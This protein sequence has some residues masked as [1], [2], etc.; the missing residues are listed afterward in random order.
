MQETRLILL[1]H[2]IFAAMLCIACL[3]TQAGL[4]T[5]EDIVGLGGVAVLVGIDADDV[6]KLARAGSGRLIVEGLSTDAT[7]AAEARV[8]LAK[9]GLFPLAD[10][11][12]MPTL[13]KLP[14]VDAFASL[15]VVDRDALGKASPDDAEIKRVLGWGRSAWVHENGKWRR[16]DKPITP[17][18]GEWTHILHGP[19]RVPASNDQVLGPW[20]DSVRWIAAFAPADD[21]RAVGGAMTMLSQRLAGGRCFTVVSH[22]KKDTLEC[23]DAY[24]GTRV[25]MRPIAWG[26][27]G[28]SAR[29]F[30]SGGTLVA[31]EKEVFCYIDCNRGLVALDA[32]T[33]EFLREYDRTFKLREK[34]SAWGKRGEAP[35]QDPGA[36]AASHVML[37]GEALLQSYKGDVWRLNRKTGEIIWHYE[38]GEELWIITPT[39]HDGVIYSVLMEPNNRGVPSRLRG[40]VAIDA[41]TGK[42]L[43]RKQG[44]KGIWSTGIAGVHDT[45]IPVQVLVLEKDAIRVD[46]LRDGKDEL[47]GFD[48]KTGEQIW[49]VEGGAYRGYIYPLDDQLIE[50]PAY[51][52]IIMR[53]LKTG[54]VKDKMKYS[55]DGG[56][57][58]FEVFSGKFQIRGSQLHPRDNPKAGYLNNGVRPNCERPSIPAYGAI[59]NLTSS[60]GCD[61]FLPSG[62]TCA[63]TGRPLQPWPND[64]RHRTDG[65]ATLPGAVPALTVSGPVVDDWTNTV[66]HKGKGKAFGWRNMDERGRDELTR[67]FGNLGDGKSNIRWYGRSET[68]PVQLDAMHLVAETHGWRLEAREGEAPEPMDW[69]KRRALKKKGKL[70]P[71]PKVVWTYLA[72]GRIGT[73]PIIVDD[74]AIFGCH[75]GWVY[76]VRVKDGSLAWRS[77]AA[78]QEQ[79]MGAFSQVESSWPC[80]GVVEHDGQILTVAGRISTMDR[81]LFACA[82]DPDTG[83]QVW[84][85]RLATD[86]IF[87]DDSSKQLGSDVWDGNWVRHAQ[88]LNMPPQ[89]IDDRLRVLGSLL[90]DPNEPKGHVIGGNGYTVYADD[91]EIEP[92]I[93][94][95]VNP[96]SG[97]TN[98]MR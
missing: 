50:M 4:P 32:R 58:S 71:P 75:N 15:V 63:G 77:L 78:P 61:H 20:V 56:G 54:E 45:V 72:G 42:Q 64:Q 2:A 24:S 89:I 3:D 84:R 92:K 19:D 23:R 6:A 28:W 51:R 37:D 65:G 43:W 97:Q 91:A 67:R 74:L 13:P 46:W 80:F 62:V 93:R 8:A 82:L 49:K 9:A 34:R 53:S 5:D 70:P 27:D 66:D 96:A 33:G 95:P 68:E 40:L 18:V 30:T 86:P 57:C 98:T 47:W 83:K 87:A 76:A 12:H 21:R 7:Q 22:H 39:L 31:D 69:R 81:G 79:R 17:D 73:A 85:V 41:K 26:P 1:K 38:G 59:Y 35:I 10:V 55:T 94:K 44:I 52:N 88:T 90:V 16:I 36:F 11:R 48:P 60:C 25:W 29:M 14:H